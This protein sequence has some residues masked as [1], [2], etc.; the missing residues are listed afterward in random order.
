MY[1]SDLNNSFFLYFQEKYLV[2][3]FARNLSFRVTINKINITQ[4]KLSDQMPKINEF[5]SDRGLFRLSS[6]YYTFRIITRATTTTAL[7]CS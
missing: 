4:L 3:V 6:G 2:H 5:G 1:A 7:A